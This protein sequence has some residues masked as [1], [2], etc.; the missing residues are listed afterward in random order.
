MANPKKVENKITLSSA[1]VTTYLKGKTKRLFFEQ[2]QNTNNTESKLANEI[3]T[4]YYL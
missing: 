1:R 3:I 2:L 4:K